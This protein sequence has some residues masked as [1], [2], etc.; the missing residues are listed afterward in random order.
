M[1]SRVLPFACYMA[2]IGI[3]ALFPTDATEPSSNMILWLYPIKVTFVAILL[4]FYWNQYTELKEKPLAS[5]ADIGL[6]LCV[7]LLVYL[8]WVRMDFPW[9]RQGEQGPGYNPFLAGSNLGIALAAIRL[10]GAS[11]IVPIMEEL[12]WRSFIIRY[13]ISP[14]FISVR[15]GKYTSLSFFITVLLFGVE[16][17]LWLAGIL[18]GAA[19]NLLLYR[20]RRL[21]PVIL[22]HGLTN[23]ILG[24]HVLVKQEWIW[25]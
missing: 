22:A 1:L 13:I 5:P 9:A 2:F 23:L 15:L 16:H 6:A 12:F 7:G 25:W 17:N 19:Y 8:A 24:L 4:A 10:F 21:W 3:G 11:V 18:A 14:N 20:T